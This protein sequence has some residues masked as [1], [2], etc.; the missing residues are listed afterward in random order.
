MKNQVI[1]IVEMLRGRSRAEHN[2]KSNLPTW[3]YERLKLDPDGGLMPGVDVEIDEKAA[4]LIMKLHSY[5]PS[6]EEMQIVKDLGEAWSRFVNLNRE[7]DAEAREF[8]HHLHACQ[9]IVLSR[10]A[11]R[12]INEGMIEEDAK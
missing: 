7:H 10:G 9:C 2:S 6:D 1:K 8:I 5:C 3:V 4:D 11:Q 12:M